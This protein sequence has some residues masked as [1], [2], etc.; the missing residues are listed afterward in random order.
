[1]AIFVNWLVLLLQ[2][3][4]GSGVPDAIERL[5]SIIAVSPAS[6]PLAA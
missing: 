1:M 3:R 5:K 6:L 2:D 4:S